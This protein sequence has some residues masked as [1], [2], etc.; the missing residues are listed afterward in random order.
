M[1]SF[2][3]LQQ[4]LIKFEQPTRCFAEW[5]AFGPLCTLQMEGPMNQMLFLLVSKRLEQHS[6]QKRLVEP[7][8]V[9][10]KLQFARL[11]GFTINPAI[12]SN[13]FEDL[14]QVKSFLL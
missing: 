12:A 13:R 7:R 9:W 11:D 3:M 10:Q 14:L 8:M 4:M 2:N 5:L 6:V 1:L